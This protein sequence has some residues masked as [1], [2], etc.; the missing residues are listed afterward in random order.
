MI[1]F[2]SGPIR[3][4]QGIEFDYA[5]VHCVWALKDAGY[6]VVIV[7][8]N[9]ETVS[10]DFDTADR[11]Y[12]EPLTAEDVWNII[13]TEKPYGV[14]VAFGGQ[15]AIKLTGFLDR[16]GVK[17]L[18][19]PADS[20]DA[21]EDRERFDALLEELDIARPVGGTVMT[22][23]EAIEV[24]AVIGYPVLMR[25]SY[26]LGGQN[27]IIAFSDEDIHEYMAIILAQN[28]EN[29]VLIDKYLMGTE[30]EVDA[31]CD[32]HE[33]LIP[34]IMEHVERTGIHSGDSIAVYPAWNI[35]DDMREIIVESTTKLALAL[36][37]M[38]LVNIQYLICEGKLF[39][40]EVNP[41]SSRT[42]PLYQ[43]GHGRANGGAGYPV[44]GRRAALGH[45]LRHGAV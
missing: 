41:R 27:M 18:G 16:M 37:T 1:V 12:F 8:N 14:V 42:I 15:T 33:I 34:G 28:I 6:E 44:H 24:A 38:G 25:P 35:D 10:T 17:L 19:T 30:L 4:G 31:I 40:I 7:N 3:I 20:I 43:Q 29:P 36:K 22:E 13:E 9:P 11:L 45:G 39:V 2:G 21:A 23:T 32:G 5:S 26:V